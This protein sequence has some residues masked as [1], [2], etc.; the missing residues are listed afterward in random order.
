VKNRAIVW[1]FAAVSAVAS[2]DA[3]AAPAD[4]LAYRDNPHVAAC[5]NQYG[6]GQGGPAARSRAAF[7]PPTPK[8]VPAASEPE[9]KFVPVV[10]AAKPAAPAPSPEPAAPAFTVDRQ[11]L[12]NTVIIGAVAGSLL[13]LV[14]LGAWRLGSTLVKDCPWCASKIARSAQTCPRCFRQL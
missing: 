12:L 5:A 10:V 8:S 2:A 1:T 3:P 7:A 14:A 13:V 11:V 6:E 9:L 4:C